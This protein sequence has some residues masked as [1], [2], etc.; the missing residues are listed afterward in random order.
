MATTAMPFPPAGAGTTGA[1]E[2][3]TAAPTGSPGG[4]SGGSGESTMA[5]DTDRTKAIGLPILLI[6]AVLLAAFFTRHSLSSAFGAARGDFRRAILFFGGVVVSG[7]SIFLLPTSAWE[8]GAASLL[9]AYMSAL[10]CSP[11]LLE[12]FAPRFFLAQMV[13]FLVLVGLP[14][15]WTT[16]IL[17]ASSPAECKRWFPSW[18]EGDMCK[19]SWLSYVAFVSIAI[20]VVNFFVVIA[21]VSLVFNSAADEEPYHAVPDQQGGGSSSAM[22]Y[23]RE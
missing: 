10:L 16:G 12:A 5:I 4:S 21:L 23:A 1:S 20:I 8:Y 13:W 17:G 2:R 19:D 22:S 18:T 15:G 11:G 14:D 3:T 9:Q 7:L 6:F